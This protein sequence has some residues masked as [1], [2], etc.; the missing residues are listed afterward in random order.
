MDSNMLPECKVMF[1]NNTQEHADIK[2]A[3]TASEDRTVTA[4]NEHY[5]Q[6]HE[7]LTDVETHIK[8]GMTSKIVSN[9]VMIKVMWA[10]IIIMLGGLVGLAWKAVA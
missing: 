1:M 3:I 4:M 7:T 2:S 5:R 6:L 9:G 10:L 8:N